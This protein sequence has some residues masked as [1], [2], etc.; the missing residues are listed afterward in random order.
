MFIL[1][2]ILFSC[3]KKKKFNLTL[4]FIFLIL[5]TI[6][7][8]IF[9][10]KLHISEIFKYNLK[11]YTTARNASP[12]YTV[13]IVCIFKHRHT[14]KFLCINLCTNLVQRIFREESTN[15]FEYAFCINTY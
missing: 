12:L 1:D 5:K 10:S 11:H 9:K 2:T 15:I 8:P 4:N 13:Y 6:K 3:L 7:L 14:N